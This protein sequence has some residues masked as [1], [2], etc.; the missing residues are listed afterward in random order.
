MKTFDYIIVGGGSAGSVQANRLSSRSS[1]QVLLLEAGIDT[2]HNQVPDE[3]LDS[4][5]GKVYFNP[6][7]IWNGLRV[8]IGHQSHNNPD[9][10]P[11]TK[12]YEQ[13][14]VMG[15][16]SSINGQ[17]ANRGA[18][19]DYDE[20]GELGA[21]GWSW[22][23]CLPYFKKI[24]R[25]LDF[26]DE[27][28]GQNG[29][30][31]V[32]RIFQDQWPEYVS[33]IATALEEQGIPYLPDQNGDFKDG[34]FPVTMS[35][36][37]DRRVS[38]AIGYLDPITRRRENLRIE[39]EIQVK[40]ILFDGTKAIGVVAIQHGQEHTFKSN[41]VILCSGAI[42]SPA[43]LLR[44]GIGPVGHL[45][46]LGINV[47]LER[48]G[49]GQNLMEHAAAAMSAWMP[50]EAR[51]NDITRRHIH[52]GWRYS[53]NM[54]N[55]P[56]GD[57]FGAVV[58]KSA[59]HSVGDCLGSMLAWVNKTYST[60]QLT[61]SS[62]DW[63]SEPT[64]EFN[65]LSDIR[66]L[67]RLMD[68]YRRMVGIFTSAAMQKVTRDPFPS[69]YSERVRKVGTVTT[70]N[71]IL[72]GILA[73]MLDGP[74]WFRKWLISSFIT[75]GDD[76]MTL[77]SNEEALAEYLKRSVTGTWHASCSNRMGRANDPMAVTDN[78]GRVH[79]TQGLRVVDA[80]IMPCVPCANTNFPTLM[81][82][83]KIA[84]SIL[85]GF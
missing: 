18:P 71:K 65:M 76:I 14:R 54:H 21:D 59:W 69:A 49:V 15:G 58:A 30:I 6:K 40:E 38:A 79:G 23:A 35:N 22:E 31:P 39:A 19:T 75:E 63:R 78:Q 10:R 3:I 26:D 28:H 61:L 85:A 36:L 81:V 11:P 80:S 60:G 20:W 46:N 1:N 83:E 2:P 70:K 43:M 74:S 29:R 55:A 82:A 50:P 77:M 24:E 68:C 47:R 52:L 42:H 13:A 44:A 4:Y 27:Y 8:H 45:H 66:D 37:Y 57:M 33:G 9:D 12:Q 7:F 25:D 72:T 73:E 62:A 53:S 17:L 64:V 84:D 34:Y 48:A 67:E 51:L 32:R 41:E 5:P 56:P 16:G